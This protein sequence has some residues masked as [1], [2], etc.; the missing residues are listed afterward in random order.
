MKFQ[1]TALL[2]LF[3]LSALAQGMYPNTP[4][5]ENYFAEKIKVLSEDPKALTSVYDISRMGLDRARPKNVPWSGSYWPLNQGMIASPY[6]DRTMIRPWQF[7][8][9][10]GNVKRF[11]SRKKD[12]LTYVEKMTDDDLAFLAPSEKYDLLLNDKG[13]DLST[14]IWDYAW[15]WGD[16][17]KQ[18][19]ITQIDLPS[20]D[21]I[22]PEANRFMA[23]WEGICHGWATAA[24]HVPEPKKIVNVVLADG[25]EVPF[26][27]DD[28]KALVSLLWANSMIQENV[29]LE[30]NRCWNKRPETD[31]HGR[32]I[33]VPNANIPPGFENVPGCGDIHPGMFHL[34][35][36][37]VTG[38]QGRSFIVDINPKAPVANQ[39]VSG[40]K[41]KYFNV[42]TGEES[43][44]NNAVLAYSAYRHVDP[45]KSARTPNVRSIVGVEVEFEYTDYYTP[46]MY[47]ETEESPNKFKE[48][49]YLYDLE[50]DAKGNIIGGQWRLSK[51]GSRTLISGDFK[52][53]FLWVIPKDYKKYFTAVNLEKWDV[54]SGKPA[55]ASWQN[56]A[57]G[58]HSFIYKMTKEF[59]WNEK[60]TVINSKNKK[61]IRVVPCEYQY[62]KPQPLINLV[63]QL[64]EL[65]K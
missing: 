2:S 27:P 39:P 30:G 51:K 17:K 40:Y 25:R 23:L 50:L 63:D 5:K 22:V 26:Y 59:G 28:I 12:Y 54:R 34:T 58:A 1:M 24:G 21:F 46:G 62:P 47:K 36:A 9:W 48:L 52:P 43:N 6:Q 19:F 61:D 18:G 55:P 44:L 20:P 65:S 53:D 38:K 4:F 16:S 56:V 14:K 41:F 57:K 32:Y 49:K 15:R 31:K 8:T 33:D 10:E 29:M 45:F 42:E 60:C 35:L 64:V 13:Y 11:E 3:S 37:N 7:V